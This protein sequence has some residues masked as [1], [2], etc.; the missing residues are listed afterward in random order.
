MQNYFQLLDLKQSYDIDL[1]ILDKQYFAMQAKYHPDRA[2]TTEEKE[3]NLLI[4]TELNKA[5]STL[6]DNLKR[7]EYMLFLHNIDLNDEEVRKKI[8]TSELSIFWEAMEEIENTDSFDALQETK[9]KYELI[10]K[11]EIDSLK[12][13]FEE[14]NLLEMTIKTSKLKYI[15]TLLRLLRTEN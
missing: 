1:K 5:Y 9:S 4:A 11:S 13:A 6:K 15:Q 7:A 14:Q 12:K 8:S 2:K 10:E 3:Q